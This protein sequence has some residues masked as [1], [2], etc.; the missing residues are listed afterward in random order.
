MEVDGAP[1][2]RPD[3]RHRDICDGELDLVNVQCKIQVTSVKLKY[4]RY[5][6]I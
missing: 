1:P 5:L 4:V 6:C 2:A 3:R